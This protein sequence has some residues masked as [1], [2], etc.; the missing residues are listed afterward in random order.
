MIPLLMTASALASTMPEVAES[1]GH[2]QIIPALKAIVAETIG[3]VFWLTDW[4]RMDVLYVSPGYEKIWGRSCESL[5]ADSRSW[6]RDIHPQDR[7]RDQDAALVHQLARQSV[8]FGLDHVGEDLGRF[9]A[10]LAAATADSSDP[11]DAAAASFSRLG[12]SSGENNEGHSWFT[13][14]A[15][16]GRRSSS[17]SF[18]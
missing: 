7:G 11:F 13:N 14:N 10:Q 5:S 3:E 1:K 6:S 17:R 16:T 2:D 9:V 4:K 15:P 18:S 8:E 12:C